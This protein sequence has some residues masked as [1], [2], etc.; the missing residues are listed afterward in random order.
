MDRILLRPAEAAEALG[1]SRSRIYELL[2]A[3]D[4]PSVR[5]GQ[6][7]RVPSDA[8]RRWVEKHTRQ[9]R[10]LSAETA[11]EGRA[12]QANEGHAN[13]DASAM[14]S[15]VPSGASARQPRG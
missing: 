3:G 11:A 8:L 1:V 10:G 5:L 4:L 13:A 14:P 15:T 9:P 6:C 7:I 12:G 2:A